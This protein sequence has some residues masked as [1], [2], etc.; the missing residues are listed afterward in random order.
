MRTVMYFPYCLVSTYVCIIL[1]C[2]T[3]APT[4]ADVVRY[5]SGRLGDRSSTL[6]LTRRQAYNCG[7]FPRGSGSANECCFFLHAVHRAAD[8]LARTTTTGA[9]SAMLRPLETSRTDDSPPNPASLRLRRNT[10]AAPCSHTRHPLHGHTVGT[11]KPSAA[12]TQ[13][14]P[15]RRITSDDV[16]RTPR[17][18][19]LSS[20]TA[21]SINLWAHHVH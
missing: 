21:N 4:R 6:I 11:R 13:A 8:L 12:A 16:V 19:F 14:V 1:I 10:T 9:G 5:E 7:H 3:A 20:I 15:V 18:T 17:V 2:C